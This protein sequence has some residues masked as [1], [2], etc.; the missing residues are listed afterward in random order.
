MCSCFRTI[1]KCTQTEVVYVFGS[2]NCDG[3]SSHLTKTHQFTKHLNKLEYGKMLINSKHL[4]R[5]PEPSKWSL[6]LVH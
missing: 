5:F 3:F 6:S 4:Q 1:I 2:F